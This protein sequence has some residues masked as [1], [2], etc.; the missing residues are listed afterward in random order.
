MPIEWNEPFGIVM[1]EAM[2]CG[3]PVLGFPLG[4][5]PEVVEHGVN[6]FICADVDD[7][8]RLVL[9]VPSIH[10]AD[11][12]RTAEARFSSDVIVDEYL[13]LYSRLRRSTAKEPL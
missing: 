9:E 1:A 13:T 12:R 10:R 8:A 7:M 4:A 2:A 11:V 5:V 6:G 3:T